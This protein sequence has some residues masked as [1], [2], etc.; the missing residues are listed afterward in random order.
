MYK[1]AR[2]FYGAEP[3]GLRPHGKNEDLR[4]LM[5]KWLGVNGPK[6]DVLRADF[7]DFGVFLGA[8]TAGEAAQHLLSG[9]R[10]KAKATVVAYKTHMAE[11]GLQ[12]AT[13]NRRLGALRN[14]VTLAYT[15]GRIRW[16]ILVGEA[17]VSKKPHAKRK[18]QFSPNDV[19]TAVSKLRKPNKAAQ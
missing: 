4:A 1:H 7:E 2:G 8:E 15:L 5:V 19:R 3:P 14:L 10:R 9:T 16:T 11:R 12:A 6:S 18:L 17:A 13:I